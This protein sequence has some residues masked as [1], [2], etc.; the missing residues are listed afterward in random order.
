MKKTHRI[1]WK[2]C[3]AR[4][5]EDLKI[6]GTDCLN[7]TQ[8]MLE[9][10]E[11]SMPLVQ[12][13]Q[14][15]WRFWKQ[16]RQHQ[17]VAEQ[18]HKMASRCVEY[19][20]LRMREACEE[21]EPPL[22]PWNVVADYVRAPESEQYRAT[23]DRVRGVLESIKGVIAPEPP[24]AEAMKLVGRIVCKFLN[25]DGTRSRKLL[26]QAVIILFQ[27]ETSVL[28]IDEFYD[29]LRAIASD[30]EQG[31]LDNIRRFLDDADRVLYL[32]SRAIQHELKNI[33]QQEL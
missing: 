8:V 13:M 33:F 29:S 12:V 14:K 10:A 4:A 1:P 16:N 2:R 24:D 26:H 7:L 17:L 9:E 27:G 25:E 28:K 31:F 32:S 21:I 23:A 22:N 6:G 3:I 11:I 19:L 5:I 20:E 18:V 30:L 15:R